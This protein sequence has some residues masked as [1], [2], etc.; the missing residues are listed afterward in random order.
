MINKNKVR[1]LHGKSWIK[2]QYRQ[3]LK[4]ETPCGG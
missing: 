3:N 4:I 2:K 1:Q